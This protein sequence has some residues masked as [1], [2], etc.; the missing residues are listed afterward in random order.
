MKT[1]EIFFNPICGSGPAAIYFHE[2]PYGDAIESN[3]EIGIGF[4]SR[5]GELLAVEFDEVI[6]IKDTQILEFNSAIV[7]I[8]A[9]QSKI[10]CTV[11]LVKKKN[12]KKKAA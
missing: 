11:T 4:F 12:N 9:K 3:N 2:G 7:K 5:S 6:A 8:V 10:S 1:P